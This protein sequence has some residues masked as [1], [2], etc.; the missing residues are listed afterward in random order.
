MAYQV[1]IIQLHTLASLPICKNMHIDDFLNTELCMEAGM[2]HMITGGNFLIIV[3]VD[4]LYKQSGCF[5]LKWV[6]S[7][8][9]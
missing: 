8:L 7:V 1:H 2:G 4:N 3:F 6:V 5:E 9:L